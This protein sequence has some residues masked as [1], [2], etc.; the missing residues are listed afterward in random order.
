LQLGI[1][2]T[3]GL[4]MLFFG[5]KYC[6]GP[7]KNVTDV[8]ITLLFNRFLIKSQCYYLVFTLINKKIN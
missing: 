6:I 8:C 1:R 2:G 7:K 3:Y 4:W 5:Y